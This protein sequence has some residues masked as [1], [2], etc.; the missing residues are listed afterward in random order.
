MIFL[1]CGL[2][3]VYVSLHV[4]YGVVRQG[5]GVYDIHC[6]LNLTSLKF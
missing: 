6:D 3:C 1:I 2:V 4:K 5:V